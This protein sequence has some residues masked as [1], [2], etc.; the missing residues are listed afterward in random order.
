MMQACFGCYFMLVLEKQDKQ[1]QGGQNYQMFYAVVQLIG[2]KKEAENFLYRY[3]TLKV[4]TLHAMRRRLGLSCP[5][6]GVDS[7]GRPL[8]AVFTRASPVLFSSQTASPL[9][10]TTRSCS[11]RT[12]TWASTLLSS[13]ARPSILER[14]C[15]I[16]QKYQ[17]CCALHLVHRILPAQQPTMN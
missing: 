11:P 16:Y 12:A 4:H 7:A 5:T 13:I 15:L 10:P 1:D 2:A 9:I 6:S 3:S 8:R 14:S 17:L